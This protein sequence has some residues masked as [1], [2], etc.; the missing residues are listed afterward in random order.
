ME[1]VFIE[2]L[3]AK[4]CMKPVLY[5]HYPLN[6]TNNP[7]KRMMMMSSFL[8]S[9]REEE[10]AKKLSN[11]V[12]HG[13]LKLQF[14]FSMNFKR[15]FSFFH[16]LLVPFLKS[17]PILGTKNPIRGMPQGLSQLIIRLLISTRS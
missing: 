14:W 2:L 10:S 9:N 13:E 16:C 7:E 8:H 5:I 3:Y 11:F 15:L 12:Q 4:N 6:L 1:L 17:F